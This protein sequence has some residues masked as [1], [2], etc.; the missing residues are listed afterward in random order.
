MSKKLWVCG[1]YKGE[2]KIGVMWDLQGIF[3]TKELAIKACRNDLYFIGPVILDEAL[4]DETVDWPGSFY[5]SL[6]DD[7]NG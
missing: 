2:N 5:P 6:E 7:P 1:K 4:P 3:S